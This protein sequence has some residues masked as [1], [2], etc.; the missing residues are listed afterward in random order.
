MEMQYII[1]QQATNRFRLSELTKHYPKCPLTI[2][3]SAMVLQRC[4][5]CKKPM[6][7]RKCS[8]EQP[9]GLQVLSKLFYLKALKLLQASSPSLYTFA[10]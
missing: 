10:N 5:Y 1:C 6:N 2:W 3:V 9:F 7:S 4:P 8:K